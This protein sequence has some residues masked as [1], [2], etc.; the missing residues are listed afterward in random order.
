MGDENPFD[1]LR[2][3]FGTHEIFFGVVQIEE[4]LSVMVFHCS[5]I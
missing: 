2:T 5:K 1:F 3:L 4:I